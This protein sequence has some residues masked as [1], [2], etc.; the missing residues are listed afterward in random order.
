M[1]K[2]SCGRIQPMNPGSIQFRTHIMATRYVT[3]LK[4]Y[5]YA[6]PS[7]MG[8]FAG[9]TIPSCSAISKRSDRK[10]H[11]TIMAF[12]LLSQR[13]Q[14]LSNSCYC[15]QSD[16]VDVTVTPI[17]LI[18]VRDLIT[19]DNEHGLALIMPANTVQF[20]PQ[21]LSFVQKI[22]PLHEIKLRISHLA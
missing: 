7:V 15:S 12:L 16:H 20:A 9:L 19:N 13:Q 17:C 3:Y 10:L 2:L 6:I 11:A 8:L 22:S 5:S 4:T 18:N 21:F 14:L 1:K